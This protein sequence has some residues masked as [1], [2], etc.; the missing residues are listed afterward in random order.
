MRA[1][2]RTKSLFL[3]STT[4]RVL[5]PLTQPHR[6][7]RLSSRKLRK[8]PR[9]RV[10]M[11]RRFNLRSTLRLQIRR[12]FRYAAGMV[13]V[14]DVAVVEPEPEP[15]PAEPAPV[16]VPSAVS[17]PDQLSPEMIDAIARRVVELMSD[18][19]MREIAWEVVPDLAELLIKEQLE[20]NRRSK[21]RLL[22]DFLSR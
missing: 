12:R 22:S 13:S 9:L 14:S 17:V 11:S 21:I 1:G 19:V 3:I 18:K 8:L 20:E 7:E 10:L 16:A 4:S 6:R 15:L 2:L 5:R